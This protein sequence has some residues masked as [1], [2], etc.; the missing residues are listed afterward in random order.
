MNNSPKK[1]SMIRNWSITTKLSLVLVLTA[2]IPMIVISVF[3]LSNHTDDLLNN[4]LYSLERLSISVA[5]LMDRLIE[6]TQSTVTILGG[7]TEVAAFLAASPEDPENNEALRASVETLFE[8]ALNSTS[9]YEFVYLMD[10]NGVTQVSKQ[11]EGLD[12]VQ[13]KNFADRD[14]F[15]EGMKGNYYIDV[16]VG[17]IT[18]KLG[19]YFSAPVYSEQGEIIGVIIVKLQGEAITDVINDLNTEGGDMSAFLVDQDGVVVS[20]PRGHED[21]MF[22]S[23]TQLSPEIKEKVKARFI[24]DDVTFLNI[25]ALEELAGSAK[26]GSFATLDEEMDFVLGY[27]PVEHLNWVVGMQVSRDSL[28][29]P[30]IDLAWMT[31]VSGLVLSVVAALIAISMARGIARPIS[32]LSVAAQNVGDDKPFEPS[33]IADVMALSDEVGALA[34]VFSNMVLALRSRMA[35][36]KAI[37]EI[38]QKISA[39]VDLD[40]KLNYI[41]TAIDEVIPYDAAELCFHDE[42]EKRLVVRAAASGGSIEY[43]E[44]ETARSHDAGHGYSV[45]LTQKGSVLLVPDTLE[46]NAAHIDPARK[47]MGTT[48]RSYLGVA[49]KSK[50]EVIGAIELVSS[51]PNSFNDENRRLLESIAIQIS[52]EVANAQEVQKRERQL[53]QQILNM[54]VVINKEKQAK[55]VEAITSRDF[56]KSLQEKARQQHL[57]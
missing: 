7:D 26:S 6:D 52:I 16:L 48:P 49:L 57:K 14:Y 1:N 34:R 9:L 10:A 39:G 19:F 44:P 51:Q 31:L 30:I 55:Q 27:A 41:L 32:K 22:Q 18:K 11:L 43:L 47:W 53:E 25:Y 54:D 29:D 35:D 38:G 15:I 12:S 8:N 17:R 56:F 23:L 21:W 24:R 33:D 37:Y 50:N 42:T 28:M 45:Y 46:F 4:S 40:N 5:G 2:L 3:N 36:L 20:A 13:G